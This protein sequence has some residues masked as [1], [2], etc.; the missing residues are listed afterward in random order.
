MSGKAKY[1]NFAIII[2]NGSSR[3]WNNDTDSGNR[4][5]AETVICLYRKI[6][7]LVVATIRR[8]VMSYKRGVPSANIALAGCQV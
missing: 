5:A 6:Y 8:A 7:F 2:K 4:G 3:N 1:A